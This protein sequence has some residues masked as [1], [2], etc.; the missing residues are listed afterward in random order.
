MHR[1]VAANP[2]GYVSGRQGHANGIEADDLVMVDSAFL[3]TY[4][5]DWLTYDFTGKNIILT[6]NFVIGYTP[7][8]ANDVTLTPVPEP[9]TMLLLGFGLLGLA[10]IT[11][12]RNEK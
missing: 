12:R 8:C 6:E 1:K 11:R 2:A 10:H 4:G 3:P 5:S 9:A 7:W